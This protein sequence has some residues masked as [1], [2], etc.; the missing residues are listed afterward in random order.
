MFT[1]KNA[2][3]LNIRNNPSLNSYIIGIMEQNQYAYV[4]DYSSD[5]QWM[6]I[7]INGVCGWSYSKYLSYIY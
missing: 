2:S 6:K 5:G 3:A 7:S 1:V 4:L